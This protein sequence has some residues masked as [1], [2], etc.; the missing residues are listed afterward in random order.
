MTKV[1]LSLDTTGKPLKWQTVQMS[2]VEGI[3]PAQNSYSNV[4]PKRPET[5]FRAER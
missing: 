1:V 3:N 2:A 5:S 4:L